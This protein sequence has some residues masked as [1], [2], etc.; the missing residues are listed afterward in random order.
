MDMGMIFKLKGAWDTF[1]RNHPKFPMFLAAMK[2][3][4]IR[5]GS[6]IAV[7]ITDP[8]GKTIDTNIKVTA[9]DLELFEMLKNMR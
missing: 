7:S 4:G 2:N 5:E 8:E 6:V 9:S 1:T 3:T